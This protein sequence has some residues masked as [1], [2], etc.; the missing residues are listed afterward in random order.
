MVFRRDILVFSLLSMSLISSCDK[1]L[2]PPPPKPTI[3][4]QVQFRGTWPRKD[5]VTL[6]A[7]A[8]ISFPGPYKPTDLIGG[9]NTTVIPIAL[10]YRSGDTTYR[11]EVDRARYYYLGVAQNYGNIFTDWRVVGFA[12]DERD[13]AL[14]FDLSEGVSIDSVDIVV[15]FDS[16]PRQPF[17]P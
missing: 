12:H 3:S 6:L 5:S 9:L 11:Y 15:N 14:T 17:I 10:S 4:G 7:L 16:L 13:S 8:L 1:G 2:M